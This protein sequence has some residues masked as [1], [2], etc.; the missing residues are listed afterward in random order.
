MV[1]VVL[2]GD[3]QSSQLPKGNKTHLYQFVKMSLKNAAAS[4]ALDSGICCRLAAF[5]RHCVNLWY[6]GAKNFWAISSGVFKSITIESKRCCL[7]L[8]SIHF[9][10]LIRGRVAG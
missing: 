9:L 2:I 8:K 5:H 3:F 10:P 7:L 1:A 4:S 6:G